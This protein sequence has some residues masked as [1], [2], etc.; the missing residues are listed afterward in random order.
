[1]MLPVGNSW[2][3]SGEINL[4]QY[5]VVLLN[6]LFF[7]GSLRHIHFDKVDH[8]Y[9]YFICLLTYPLCSTAKP[10]SLSL[11]VALSLLISVHTSHLA[12][13]AGFSLYKSAALEIILWNSKIWCS[14][15]CWK[16]GDF[17]GLASLHILVCLLFLFF[18]MA[19]R[20]CSQFQNKLIIE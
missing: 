17:N 16:R 9:Y 10:L 11:C 2:C 7:L 18:H 14:Y 5:G 19:Q 1:M 6:L 4:L 3:P 20:F 12:S 13:A 8:N 15:S